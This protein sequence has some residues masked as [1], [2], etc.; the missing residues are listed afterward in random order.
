MTFLTNNCWSEPVLVH[1]GKGEGILE[2]FVVCQESDCFKAYFT[3]GP[4]WFNQQ[5]WSAISQS[6]LGPFEMP[7]KIQTGKHIRLE[8]G[9]INSDSWYGTAVY[10]K[11]PK[12]GIWH[13]K[14][15]HFGTV[16]SAVIL[17]KDESLYSVSVANPCLFRNSIIF[18]GR[19]EQMPPVWRIFQ[20]DLKGNVCKQ[21]I[22]IGGNPFV[23]QFEDTIYLYFSKYRPQRGFDTWCMTQPA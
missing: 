14:N 22:C 4:E 5:L 18:E 10:R 3:S 12:T 21:P 19:N 15:T 16:R 7:R 6:P 17:P 20:S 9:V 23:T 11:L 8:K 13:H 2:D 1:S